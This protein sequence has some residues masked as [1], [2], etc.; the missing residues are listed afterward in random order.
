MA[1]Q[2]E[3]FLQLIKERGELFQLNVHGPG[4]IAEMVRTGAELEIEEVED[5]DAGKA[6]ETES[7]NAGEAIGGNTETRA[8]NS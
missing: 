7:G 2:T 4:I 3:D 8:A 1:K 5:G 6:L